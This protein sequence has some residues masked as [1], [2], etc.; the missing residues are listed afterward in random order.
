MATVLLARH[1]ETDWNAERRWQ[2]HTDRPLNER[3]RAQS[4]ALAERLDGTELAAVYSSDLERAR[5]TAA[6][7]A[8]R[9]G[10][11]HLVDADLREVDVGSWAGLTRAQAERRFPEAFARWSDGYAGWPDGETYE[12]MSA[13]VVTAVKRIAREHRDRPVLVV[14]H[15]G[16]IRAIHAAALGLD[17]QTYRRLRPVEPNARLS[18]VCLDDACSFTEL[19]PAGS[20]DDAIARD[21]EERLEA[22]RRPPTPGG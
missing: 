17:V 13:R 9:Q 4:R 20:I 3:G 21:R 1:G 8:E 7:V 14:S 10:V 22:A 16:P 5:A 6:A 15:G 2:G 19:C 11:P 18:A 12:A